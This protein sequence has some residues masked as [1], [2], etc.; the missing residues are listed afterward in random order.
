MNILTVKAGERERGGH[1]DMAVDALL[2]KNA[3]LR[4]SRLPSSTSS[5]SSKSSV[6]IKGE[7]EVKT[8][9]RLVETVVVLLLRA[10]G[11]V[12]QSLHTVSRL[13]PRAAKIRKIG[14]NRKTRTDENLK[15]SRIVGLADNDGGNARGL[16][17]REDILEILIRYLKNGARLFS[18]ELA[19]NIAIRKLNL[20][21]ATACNRHFSERYY[22]TTVGTIVIRESLLLT[23]NLLHRIKEALQIGCVAVGVGIAELRINLGERCR[24][25]RAFAVAE[26]DINEFG[27]AWLQVRR[28]RKTDVVHGREARN[29]ERKR[30]DLLLVLA[31][32]ILP[33]RMHRARVFADGNRNAE[34]RAE[35]KADFLDGIVKNR[36]FAGIAA[37]SHPVGRK[38]DLTDVANVSSS[39]VRNRLCNRHTAGS[40]AVEKR[41]GS[42]LARRH[43]LTIECLVAHRRNGAVGG[44]KLIPANHLIARYAASNRAVGNR[45]KERLIGDRGKMENAR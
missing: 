17:D 29:H 8:G 24:A 34:F 18:K 28:K 14:L 12:A 10:D 13:A 38:T 39:E 5:A 42:A 31:L 40:G 33:R 7:F 19:E 6:R 15:V 36:V 2:A 27:R 20:N 3:H 23:N 37:R 45:N 4:R 26:I 25:E 1:F 9:I 16:E 11:I 44:G 43:R 21:T 30:R 22:D 41:D 35:I 32:R